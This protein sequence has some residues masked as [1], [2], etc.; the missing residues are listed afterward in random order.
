MLPTSAIVST[1]T[2]V[3]TSMVSTS[4]RIT[5]PDHTNPRRRPTPEAYSGRAGVRRRRSPQQPQRRTAPLEIQAS[6]TLKSGRHARN[7]YDLLAHSRLVLSEPLRVFRSAERQ[8]SEGRSSY[9]NR[10]DSISEACMSSMGAIKSA[11]SV[12]STLRKL[13]WPVPDA[14]VDGPSV[15]CF[16]LLFMLPPLA[17]KNSW[18]VGVRRP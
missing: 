6:V 5:S 13:I 10:L 11:A 8:R 17:K 1:W 15:V 18:M 12:A 9:R 16:Y 2:L 7:A 14:V 3:D 4:D